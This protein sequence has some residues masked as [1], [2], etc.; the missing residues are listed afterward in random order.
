MLVGIVIAGILITAAGPFFT[1]YIASSRLREG[2]NL[3][4]TE[5]LIAQSEAIKRNASVEVVT[6]A[7]TVTV[8]T[9]AA[10]PEVLR[11][12][13]L[14]AGT[15]MAAGNAAF[16]GDGRPTDFPSATAVSIDLSHASLACSA[17]IRC[18]GLRVTAGGVIS[19]CRDKNG[20]C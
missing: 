16:R 15:S 14:P 6:T 9:V 7:T 12:R 5:A 1:D 4:L 10:T 2:G 3:L 17:S 18:P 8:Q 13:T 19:L 11:T 20:S